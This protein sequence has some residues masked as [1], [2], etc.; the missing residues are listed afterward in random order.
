LPADEQ[1]SQHDTPA[2]NAAPAGASRQFSLAFELPFII[3]GTILVGG[4]FGVFLDR[5]LGTKPIMTFVFGAL[6]FA[7]GVREVLRRVRPGSGDGSTSKK[8]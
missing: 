8:L 6:G 2:E 7:A 4:L 5:W 1:N 3:V